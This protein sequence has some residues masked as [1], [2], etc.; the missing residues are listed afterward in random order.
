M[1]H[2]PLGIPSVGSVESFL[3]RNWFVTAA[4]PKMMSM[5]WWGCRF[6]MNQK[7]SHLIKTLNF[8][9]N[10]LKMESSIFM[11]TFQDHFG[12]FSERHPK[13]SKE[14]MFFFGPLDAQCRYIFGLMGSINLGKRCIMIAVVGETEHDRRH[15]YSRSSINRWEMQKGKQRCTKKDRQWGDFCK[16]LPKLRARFQIGSLAWNGLLPWN[17]CNPQPLLPIYMCQERNFGWWLWA[18]RSRPFKFCSFPPEIKGSPMKPDLDMICFTVIFMP[19]CQS[20]NVQW[21]A[22][23]KIWCDPKLGVFAKSS[24][25]F[26]C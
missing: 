12:R 9:P 13:P 3:R 22:L 4:A 25:F 5:A 6:L 2:Q 10:L 18:V 17:F 24:N 1:P 15:S 26:H 11:A 19:P 16:M 14:D 23:K 7:I 21:D 8:F 20:R